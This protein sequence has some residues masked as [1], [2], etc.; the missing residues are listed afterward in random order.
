MQFDLNNIEMFIIHFLYLFFV[1]IYSEKICINCKYFVK[2]S[3]CNNDIYGKCSAFQKN[4][5]NNNMNYLVSGKPKKEYL[6]CI[7]AREDDKLCGLDG[8]MYIEKSNFIKDFILPIF[9]QKTI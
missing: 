6:F 9:V 2:A 1:T 4:I 3:F 7:S 8:K 5:E